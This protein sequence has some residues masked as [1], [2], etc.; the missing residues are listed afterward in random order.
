MHTLRKPSEA[1]WDRVVR[2]HW[3]LTFAARLKGVDAGIPGNAPVSGVK[4][5][6]AVTSTNASGAPYPAQLVVLHATTVP[7]GHSQIRC[8]ATVIDPMFWASS[9]AAT[10]MPAEFVR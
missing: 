6:V 4:V 9:W 5:V 3:A 7:A 1:G 2:P 10:W 8:E